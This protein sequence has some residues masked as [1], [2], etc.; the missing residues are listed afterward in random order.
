MD[1]RR[2]VLPLSSGTWSAT[3]RWTSCSFEMASE[4][5]QHLADIKKSPVSPMMN[6]AEILFFFSGFQIRSHIHGKGIR[7]PIRS[8]HHCRNK[9]ILFP[10]FKS[11]MNNRSPGISSCGSH[12]HPRACRPYYRLRHLPPL[13]PGYREE[14][15]YQ[16]TADFPPMLRFLLRYWQPH[17]LQHRFLSEWQDLEPYW[18]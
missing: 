13:P 16:E 7:H 18:R 4:V 6:L 11:S 9:D 12:F 10:S 14:F 1:Y 2:L 3:G 17:N 8:R 15:R 5:L